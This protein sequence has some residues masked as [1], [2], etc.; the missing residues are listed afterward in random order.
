MESH[1]ESEAARDLLNPIELDPLR[2][3]ES[4]ILLLCD[5]VLDLPLSPSPADEEGPHPPGLGWMIRCEEVLEE[6]RH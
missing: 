3:R 2:E 1:S 4:T 5:W 6:I